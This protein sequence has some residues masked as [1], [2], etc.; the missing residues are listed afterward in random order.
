MHRKDFLHWIFSFGLLLPIQ[1]RSQQPRFNLIF[2]GQQINWGTIADMK[3]DP[4][5]YLWMSTSIKGIQRYDGNSLISFANDPHNPNSLAAN[6]VPCLWIDSSGIIWAATY[7]GGLDRFDPEKKSFTHYRHSDKDPNS[8]SNDTVFALLRDHSGIL[9]V[10]TYGGLEILDEQTGKFRHFRNI[11]GDSAS[12]S[13]NRVWYLYEDHLNTLWV[14]CGSPFT[15]MGESREEGGLNRYNRL[16]GKFKRYLHDARNPGSLENN[17]VRAMFEDTRGNF[18]VGSAGDGLQMLDRN[19][20]TFKHFYFDPHH[21]EKLSRPA[22]HNYPNGI[23]HITWIREDPL[24]GIMIGTLLNGINRYD[25]ST[26]KITH[27]GIEYDFI[28]N[29]L[30]SAKDTTAGFTDNNTW[31]AF[32]TRDS[33]FWISTTN[34]NL[35]NINFSKSAI[36][37]FNGAANSFLLEPDNHTLWIAGYEGLVRKDLLSGKSTVW[38]HDPANKRS[39]PDNAVQAIRE[40]AKKNL[41]I[42][43]AHGLSKFDRQSENF[44]NY[45][46]DSAREQSLS[47]DNIVSLL[48]DHADNLWISAGNWTIDRLNPVT[49]RIDHFR[50]IS[51]S[52]SISSDAVFNLTEDSSGDIFMGAEGV[53]RLN[54]ANRTFYRYQQSA[55]MTS[56]YRDHTGIIW[57]GA[58]DG[59]YRFNRNEDKFMRVEESLSRESIK[60]VLGMTEDKRRNLWLCT[61]KDLVRLNADRNKFDIFGANYGVKKNTS[62]TTDMY[63]GQN[64]EIFAGDQSGYYAFYPD[65]LSNDSRGPEL[66][67]SEFLLNDTTAAA[68]DYSLKQDA[69]GK[70]AEISLNHD[71]NTFSINFF[72]IDYACPG[73]LRYF[74]QLGGLDKTWHASGQDHKAYYFSIPP[75]H[76]VFHAMAINAEGN[77]GEKTLIIVIH[78]PWWRTW[79]AYGIYLFAFLLF[80]FFMNRFIRGRIIEKEKAKTRQREFEQAKEI[81]KAYHE[82]KRT[83][84]QLIQ[85]E[86]MASLGELT[87]GI[88]HEIQN[89][90][91]FVNNF[92]EINK[93]LLDETHEA[94][95]AG[96]SAE[97]E[98]LLITLK[99]NEEK[100]SQHGKRADSIVKGMLQH[101]RSASGQKEPVDINALADEYL[102]LA[103]HGLRSKDKTF[104]A[105][106][107]TDF[108][109]SIGKINI[110]PQDIGRVLLNLYNNAFYAVAEKS[111]TSG[112]DYKPTINVVTRPIPP[113][114]GHRGAFVEIKVSDNGSGI[115]KKIMD[116]IFQPF[117]TT[118]PTG[119]GTGLGLSISYDIIKAHGGEIRV[120]SSPDE[121]PT[122]TGTGTTF[123]LLLPA[124]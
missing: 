95:K 113:P 15:N 70:S 19:T 18:W 118:K 11:Q 59:L 121:G 91:N 64:G 44:I 86:K 83:Q 82:L 17:K 24:G 43:T 85:S 106:L 33:L 51:G 94:V 60:G 90:L 61:A 69:W 104:N 67:F 115:P 117:F 48:I 116:K 53:Y 81:E 109:P 31:R 41:W 50:F 45:F 16:T 6:R 120:D 22:E 71:Q 35:Y 29:K 27:F 108:D 107:N 49:E 54:L 26:K 114:G 57:A 37:Y 65:Q 5:G 77:R 123:I 42:G 92:S 96:N 8:I 23:D 111:K 58:D 56:L 66:S 52:S 7:G 36:P 25:P 124:D 101:S 73:E 14:G 40:D 62:F 79:W 38:K 10:G 4:K 122:E 97:V 102:R 76:Y 1:L 72:G 2:S 103:Y 32:S 119:Q 84:A 13:Y 89:P 63:T 12:L 3:Q 47:G 99:E 110:I 34:G 21:P 20:G 93:E 68:T 74:F 46:H 39:L 87:A 78:P 98:N 9:W 112:T 30:L 80:S 75:G 28:S 55:I 105:T 88:A 100:I